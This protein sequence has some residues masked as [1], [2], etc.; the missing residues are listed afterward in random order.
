MWGGYITLEMRGEMP[1]EILN[2]GPNGEGRRRLKES[3]LKIICR[4]DRWERK[5]F[6]GYVDGEE[7][8]DE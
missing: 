8:G 7:R 1:S 2:Q 5:R 3:Q 6:E 4:L